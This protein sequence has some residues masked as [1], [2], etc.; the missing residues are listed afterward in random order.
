MCKTRREALGRRA[1]GPEPS[2]GTADRPPLSLTQGCAN[3]QAVSP[4]PAQWPLRFSLRLPPT[5][6]GLSPG[7]CM[8]FAPPVSPRWPSV[9]FRASR[10]SRPCRRSGLTLPTHSPVLKGPGSPP[11]FDQEAEI[12]R[13]RVTCP[14]S[15]SSLVVESGQKK[16]SP[17]LDRAPREPTVGRRQSLLAPGYRWLKLR[18]GRGRAHSGR[19]CGNLWALSSLS[20]ATTS[21]SCPTTSP[22]SVPPG[23]RES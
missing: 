10:I 2:E 23:I 4:S 13:G 21:L 15:H 19:L 5:R 18:P 7:M 20:T 17:S 3:A 14:R 1:R 11:F 6:P 9:W 16:Q 22:L 12:Q 8:S